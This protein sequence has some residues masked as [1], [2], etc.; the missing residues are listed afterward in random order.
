MTAADPKLPHSDMDLT[1]D[2]NLSCVF[3]IELESLV[4]LS[5]RPP[6]LQHGL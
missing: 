3:G 5:I 1:T 6:W 2:L 4:A